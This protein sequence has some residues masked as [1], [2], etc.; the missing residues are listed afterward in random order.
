LKN[1]EITIQEKKS[2]FRQKSHHSG[3]KIDPVYVYLLS[4]LLRCIS[5]FPRNSKENLSVR[6]NESGKMFC[7]MLDQEF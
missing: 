5:S 7:K 3:K 6:E 2:P 1:K 4:L